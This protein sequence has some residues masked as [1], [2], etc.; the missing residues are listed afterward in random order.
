MGRERKEE[1]HSG[2]RKNIERGQE[3]VSPQP[4]LGVPGNVMAPGYSLCAIGQQQERNERA[5]EMAQWVRAPDCSSKSPEFKSQQPHGG[6]QP[7][8]MRSDALFWC[9]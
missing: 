8:I 9:V 7:S 5:G 4:V 6:S 2:Q 3:N 1:R